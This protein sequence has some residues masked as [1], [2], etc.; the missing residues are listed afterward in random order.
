MI[1]NRPW[2]MAEFFGKIA[3]YNLWIAYTQPFRLKLRCLMK[4]TQY[5]VKAEKNLLKK[6]CTLK[7]WGIRISS[8]W[9][10]LFCTNSSSLLPPSSAELILDLKVNFHN[11]SDFFK[12]NWRPVSKCGKT[13][14]KLERVTFSPLAGIKMSSRFLCFCGSKGTRLKLFKVQT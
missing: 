11:Y 8:A 4:M 7:S 5:E 14:A 3:I 13:F 9:F 2:S 1:F 12:F 10:F 6:A